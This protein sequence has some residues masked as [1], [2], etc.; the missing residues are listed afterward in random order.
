MRHNLMRASALAVYLGIGSVALG[1]C[2]AALPVLALAPGVL[3]AFLSYKFYQTTSGTEVEVAFE[4]D[5]VAHAMEGE[6]DAASTVAYWPTS[7]RALVVAAERS[8]AQ[9]GFERVLAPAST[10]QELRSANIPTDV[11]NLTQV[12]RLQAF[13]DASSR[14]DADIIIAISEA[15]EGF[16]SSFMSLR[17]QL[18]YAYQVYLYDRSV[19]AEL[20]NTTLIASLRMGR[21]MV[22][23]GEVE[24]VAGQAI[25]DRLTDFARGEYAVSYLDDTENTRLV[26]AHTAPF[27][28]R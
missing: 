22:G 1:G 8:Q 12:E 5:T 15:D 19:D 4:Q 28:I 26:E 18:T 11:D 6:L 20:W 17:N 13:R 23:E 25:V 24:A 9:F 14:L 21:S 3:T 16:E 2:V 27:A 7:N 10:A